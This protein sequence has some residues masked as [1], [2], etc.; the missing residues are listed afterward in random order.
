VK[1]WY[2]SL[3]QNRPMADCSQ[4]RLHATGEKVPT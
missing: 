1:S 2:R 3:E 4:P